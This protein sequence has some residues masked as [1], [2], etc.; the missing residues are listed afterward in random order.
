MFKPR[1]RGEPDSPNSDHGGVRL[2]RIGTY[3][4]KNGQRTFQDTL[5]TIHSVTTHDGSSV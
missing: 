4:D 1:A 2:E 5:G 3:N